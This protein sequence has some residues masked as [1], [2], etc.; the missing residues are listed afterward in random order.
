MAPSNSQCNA[1]VHF[2][3]EKSKKLCHL[4]ACEFFFGEGDKRRQLHPC[5]GSFLT[6][7]CTHTYIYI[8]VCMQTHAVQLTIHFY[9]HQEKKLSHKSTEL[10]VKPLIHQ[11]TMIRG[12][13]NRLQVPGNVCI[14]NM[15]LYYALQSPIFILVQ[16]KNKGNRQ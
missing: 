5:G 9:L 8:N 4:L 13:A 1:P 11:E 2:N 10:A 14:L 3:L 15:Q 7:T 12:Q 6:L 16:Q